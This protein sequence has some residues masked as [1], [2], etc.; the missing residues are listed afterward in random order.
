MRVVSSSRGGAFA[1]GAAVMAVE[2]FAV[3]E[4]LEEETLLFPPA[5]DLGVDGGVGGQRLAPGLLR[6]VPLVPLH[7]LDGIHG[8]RDRA[9]AEI[10]PND[11]ALAFPTLGQ[12]ALGAP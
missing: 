3:E 6:G 4:G 1:P 7:H 12:A 10:L 9:S 11:A 2:S 5:L 8:F